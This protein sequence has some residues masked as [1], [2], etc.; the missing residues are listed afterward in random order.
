M[1]SIDYIINMIEKETKINDSCKNY[2]NLVQKC[3]NQSMNDNIECNLLKNL[4]DNCLIYQNQNQK[5]KQKQK[6]V[7]DKNN[8]L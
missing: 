8:N 1:D 4:Y 6:L 3:N 5:Q 2:K 7:N